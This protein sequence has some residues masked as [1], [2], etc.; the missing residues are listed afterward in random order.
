MISYGARLYRHMLR[1]Y[2]ADHREQFEE[3]M[4]TVFL[5]LE[6]E[7][8]GQGRAAQTWFCL[9]ETAGIIGS[10]LRARLN[11]LADSQIWHELRSERFRMRSEF[12]FPKA[13]AVL[14]MIILAGVMLAIQRGEAISSSLPHVNPAIGPIHPVHSTMLGGAIMGVAFFYG[15]GLVG[16]AILFFMRRSGVHRLDE[17]AAK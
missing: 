17:T 16:W 13:T 8:G 5:E 3:E 1:L 15:A 7:R 2:P 10:A 9:R 11:I 12:R 6:Q 14:M 4:I